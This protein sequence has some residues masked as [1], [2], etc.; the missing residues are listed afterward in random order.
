MRAAVTLSVLGSLAGCDSL[1][2]LQHLRDRD[3]TGDGG[4]A[5]ATPDAPEGIYFQ[6]VASS[7]GQNADAVAVPI[8]V[9]PG[10]NQVMVIFVAVGTNCVDTTQ[11]STK[12]VALDQAT[13]MS[14]GFVEGTPCRMQ[15]S[16]S[17]VWLVKGP[18][19]GANSVVVALNGSAR[20]LHAS[21]LVF[22]GVNL[23]EPYRGPA[24]ATGEGVASTLM[25]DSAP[26][27]MVVSFVA[28]GTMI[29]GPV[30]PGTLRYLANVNA[31][32]TLNNTAA[33]TYPGASPTVTATWTFGSSDQYQAI[34]LSLKPAS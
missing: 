34:A 33:S 22:A 9:P 15:L 8:M 26:D 19:T 23:A 12:S 11:P 2:G 5:D 28:Q 6:T 14:I 1:F 29:T 30:A 10:E 21:A 32:T 27:D 24:G 17:E 25:V 31:D 13:P 3:A 4:L 20:S 16:R 18:P 7:S